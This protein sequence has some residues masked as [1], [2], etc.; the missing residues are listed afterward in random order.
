MSV[1]TSLVLRAPSRRRSA[2]PAALPQA[3]SLLYRTVSRARHRTTL[4]IGHLWC[5]RWG[6]GFVDVAAADEQPLELVAHREIGRRTDV[7]GISLRVFPPACVV[8]PAAREAVGDAA[9][10]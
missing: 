4:K 9:S 8:V 1:R 10:F 3:F 7:V 5:R 2:S 6:K